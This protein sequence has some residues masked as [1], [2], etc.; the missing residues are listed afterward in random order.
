MS[1]K[2]PQRKTELRVIKRAESPKDLAT[3]FF[4]LQHL[5]KQVQELEQREQELKRKWG[6]PAVVGRKQH[7]PENDSEESE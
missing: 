7:G 1:S 2:T 6:V 3:R 5:R 4:E